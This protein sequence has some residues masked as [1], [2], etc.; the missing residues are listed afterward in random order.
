MD[1]HGESTA[2]HR[3]ILK[4]TEPYWIISITNDCGI[5]IVAPDTLVSP[6]KIAE[7]CTCIRRGVITDRMRSFGNI[8]SQ[9]I[10]G[11]VRHM[12]IEVT[13]LHTHPHIHIP[14]GF[15]MN[16]IVDV[17]RKDLINYPGDWG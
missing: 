3:T 11:N 4:S 13:A 2:D 8:T 12:F 6:T 7:S 10:M 1:I 5:L 17:N 9:A 14:N 15:D 16:V